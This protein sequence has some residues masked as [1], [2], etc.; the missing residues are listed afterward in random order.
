MLTAKC[1]SN[2]DIF[3]EEIS[4]QLEINKVYELDVISMR[5]DGAHIRL[6]GVEGD[7]TGVL[8]EFYDDGEKINGFKMWA[9]V[10]F[11]DELENL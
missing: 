6:I 3:T 10:I 7:F 4:P 9:K 11:G 1:I 2:K 8:F 5:L